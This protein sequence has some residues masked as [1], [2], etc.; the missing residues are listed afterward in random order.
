MREIIL[1]FVPV[2]FISHDNNPMFFIPL[3]FSFE[4]AFSFVEFGGVLVFGGTLTKVINR[5]LLREQGGNLRDRV[6]LTLRT[7]VKVLQRFPC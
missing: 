2:N 6:L 5:K 4:K 1:C 3:S 7:S